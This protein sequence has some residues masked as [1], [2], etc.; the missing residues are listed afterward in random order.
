M[1]EGAA[2]APRRP[3]RR[4]GPGEG[5][6]EGSEMRGGDESRGGAGESE[7]EGLASMARFGSRE[8]YASNWP[9]RSMFTDLMRRK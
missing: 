7:L 8:T 4:D 3:P 6:G 9:E 2:R 5:R 1:Y